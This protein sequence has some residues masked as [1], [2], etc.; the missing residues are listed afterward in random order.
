[1]EEP[2]LDFAV[3][4]GL[5]SPPQAAKA[6]EIAAKER[7]PAIQQ[8]ISSGLLS[9]VKLQEALS[10]RFSIPAITVSRFSTTAMGVLPVERMQFFGIIPF[11]LEPDGTLHVAVCEPPDVNLL[12]SHGRDG[13]EDR[14]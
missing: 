5:V 2:L 10:K 7:V 9:E 6:K 3:K 4:E 13:T 14:P 11:K 8:L 12:E 1:M